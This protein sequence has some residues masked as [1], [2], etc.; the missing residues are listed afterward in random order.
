[1]KPILFNTDMVR[2]I[3]DGRKTVTRRVIKGQDKK[4]MYAGS[5]M[6]GAGLFDDETCKRVIEP[7]YKV[8]DVLYI[9]ETWRKITDTEYGYRA[10]C[11]K[12]NENVFNWKPSI[13]M[14]KEAARIFL[15]ITSIK[16]AELRDMKLED[17]LKEGIYIKCSEVPLRG[18][19][20]ILPVSERMAAEEH[21][22]EA[23]ARE[24]FKDLWNSTIDKPYSTEQYPNSWHGN[25]YVWVIEFEVITADQA[26]G[27]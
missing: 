26:K 15:K 25:P 12:A 2:A 4:T 14:P 16:A 3:L 7:P 18:L 19:D 11:H 6:L 21:R 17:F 23:V 8:G 22:K 1:M 9:R 27:N 5:C 13:H 20:L 10:D 24:K